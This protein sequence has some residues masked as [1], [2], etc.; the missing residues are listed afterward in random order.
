MMG[1]AMPFPLMMTQ[2]M[3]LVWMCNWLRRGYCVRGKFCRVTTQ[4]ASFWR[5]IGL[6]TY[7]KLQ[8]HVI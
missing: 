4:S 8:E 7:A 2:A 1:G 5:V 6:F 3:P